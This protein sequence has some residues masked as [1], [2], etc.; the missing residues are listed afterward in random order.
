MTKQSNFK[1][2]FSLLLLAYF[3]HLSAAQFRTAN[4]SKMISLQPIP[5]NASTTSIPMIN[6]N[7]PT[8]E[9]NGTKTWINKFLSPWFIVSYIL[10]AILL[11]IIFSYLHN[12][13][14]VNECLLLHL[15]K[16]VV[17]ILISSRIALVLKGST[18]FFI[19][20]SHAPLTMNPIAAMA[21]SFFL[22]SVSLSLLI[23]LSIIG[24]LRLY[25]AKTMTLDPPIPWGID[26]KMG[27]R[28]IRILIAGISIGYPAMM[29]PFKI[30]PKM[31]YDFVGI[32]K[33]SVPK[34]SAMYSGSLMLFLMLFLITLMAEQY[35]KNSNEQQTN[36]L[37]PRQI[38]YFLVSNTLLYGYIS[39]EITFQFLDSDTRWLVFELLMSVLGISTPATAIFRSEKVKS[40]ALK[41]LKEKYESAFLMNMYY[42]PTSVTILIYGSLSFI[43]TYFGL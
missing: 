26:E 27:T 37:I 9:V 42:I 1:K 28:I 40:Y 25:M 6:Y 12:I 36:N 31:Y 14:V 33:S 18:S 17:A 35:Y 39:F 8:L 13:S 43:Y 11:I 24:I 5:K 16:D 7:I 4:E 2:L 41:F 29:Y 15:Y 30:Y 38:N 34:L 3:C 10:S 22:T 20:D 32:S 23:T 19:I 21:I